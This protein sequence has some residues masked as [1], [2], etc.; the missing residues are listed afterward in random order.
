M[1]YKKDEVGF[2]CTWALCRREPSVNVVKWAFAHFSLEEN[3]KLIN[4]EV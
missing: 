2:N 3:K 4:N 1:K